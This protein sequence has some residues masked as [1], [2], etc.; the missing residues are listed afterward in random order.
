M[1]EPGVSVIIPNV[2]MRLLTKLTTNHPILCNDCV[3]MSQVDRSCSMAQCPELVHTEPVTCPHT[4][5]LELW[6]SCLPG[7]WLSSQ[8]GGGLLQAG[9]QQIG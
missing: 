5:M 2:G 8:L 3:Y 7:G 9:S 6:L 1:R 4:C